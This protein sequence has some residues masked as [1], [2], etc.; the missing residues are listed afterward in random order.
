MSKGGRKKAHELWCDLF[1]LVVPPLL[2]RCPASLPVP[3]PPH[4][5]LF[6]HH[7]AQTVRV[8]P[9]LSR[10]LQTHAVMLFAALLALA[11][12][13]TP[14][15]A[16]DTNVAA[17]VGTDGSVTQVDVQELSLSSAGLAVS[18]TGKLAHC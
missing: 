13:A 3:S 17:E 10:C 11:F 12:L 18:R 1:P 2:A 6:A 9:V 14:I 8:T 4:F 5:A 16:T 15:L 7:V